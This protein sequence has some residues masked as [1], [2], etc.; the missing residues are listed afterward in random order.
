MY[1]KGYEIGHVFTALLKSDFDEFWAERTAAVVSNSSA[2]WDFEPTTS[3]KAYIIV[4]V[5][6]VE[7]VQ[8]RI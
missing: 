6:I 3:V 8:N 5:Q 7:K 1:C 4:S 2:P